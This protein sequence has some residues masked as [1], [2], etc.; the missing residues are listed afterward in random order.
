MPSAA[1]HGR[2]APCSGAPAREVID[3]QDAVVSGAMMN[4]SVGKIAGNFVRAVAQRDKLGQVVAAAGV[5]VLQK[6]RPASRAIGRD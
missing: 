5:C 4:T 3:R 1:R 6:P 2:R